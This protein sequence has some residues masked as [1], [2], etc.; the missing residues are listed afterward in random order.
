MQEKGVNHGKIN[1]R[2]IL[3]EEGGLKILNTSFLNSCNAYAKLLTQTN[4]KGEELFLS[5]KLMQVN[6]FVVWI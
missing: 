1:L 4:D 2:N 5:P 3:V 6:M